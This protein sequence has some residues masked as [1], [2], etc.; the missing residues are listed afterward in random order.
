MADIFDEV[1]EDIRAERVRRLAARYGGWVVGAV[2]LLIAGVAGWQVWQAREAERS[3]AVAG[4]YIAALR[5]AGETPPGT[6]APPDRA[7]AAA[8]LARL[9]ESA[10]GGYRT[11]A[12]LRLAAL[13]AEAGDA[14]A[15]LALWEQVAA[16]G[17]A[18]TLLR[19][20]AALLWAQRQVDAGDPS[21]IEA[22]LRPLLMPTNPW[23]SLAQ[24]VDALLALRLGRT[25]Q[26]RQA[27]RQLSADASAPA[28][29]RARAE[30]LL[31]RLGETAPTATAGG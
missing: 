16:D 3:A 5:G 26:A 15:A 10:P 27:F 31:A 13:R 4:S 23:R 20:L 11:L 19:D 6:D 1:S 28:G 29:V 9:A 17:A 2:L 8:E 12:R 24:E 22:R 14:P 7:P 21:A 18:D 25:D 30:A